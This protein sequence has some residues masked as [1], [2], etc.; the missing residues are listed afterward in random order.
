MDI[1][2]FM[3]ALNTILQSTCSEGPVQFLEAHSFL[4]IKTISLPCGHLFPNLLMQ[5]KHLSFELKNCSTAKRVVFTCAGAGVYNV[6]GI[7][8][9]QV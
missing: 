9:A 7:P 6:A 8:L 1:C 4:T 2:S 3:V 5:W